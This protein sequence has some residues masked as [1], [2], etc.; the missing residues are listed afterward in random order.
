MKALVRVEDDW[1]RHGVALHMAEE[2][3]PGILHIRDHSALSIVTEDMS[4]G[5]RVV[6]VEPLRMSEDMES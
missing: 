3:S 2:V 4:A 6:D 1:M 5:G